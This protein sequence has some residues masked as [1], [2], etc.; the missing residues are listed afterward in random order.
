ME[1]YQQTI[2]F[3]EKIIN[4]KYQAKTYRNADFEGYFDMTL[5]VKGGEI[6][7][8][9]VHFEDACV[10]EYG[11]TYFDEG[12]LLDFYHFCLVLQQLFHITQHLP[13]VKV[14]NARDIERSSIKI[15]YNLDLFDIVSV[16]NIIDVFARV[17]LEETDI[18][19]LFLQENYSELFTFFNQVRSENQNKFAEYMEGAW[20]AKS[21]VIP[22]YEKVEIAS[23]GSNAYMYKDYYKKMVVG[24]DINA[25]KKYILN[26]HLELTPLGNYY[27]GVYYNLI[28]KQD[29]FAVISKLYWKDVITILTDLELHF[30]T[31]PTKCYYADN[32]IFIQ[33]IDFW[34]CILCETE[35]VRAKIDYEINY[36]GNAYN[37]LATYGSQKS[38][39]SDIDLNTI[40]PEKFESMCVDLLVA[41]GFKK[42][43]QRGNMNTPDKGVDIEAVEDVVGLFGNETR[44]WIFQCKHS[45]KQINR[46][47]IAEIPLLL[48]EFEADRFGLFSSALFTPMTQDRI[49]ML[50]RDSVATFDGNQIKQILSRNPDIMKKYFL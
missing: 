38:L 22:T 10:I 13:D 25:M 30:N 2:D 31:I 17:N 9:V 16:I 12:I 5:C 11:V 48:K 1:K 49:K 28:Q 42:T 35:K 18:D 41:Q 43:C 47:D 36:I 3:L 7:I 44:K 34:C 8:S 20:R 4:E 24:F 15:L 33:V 21:R 37:E 19:H 6:D 26:Q 32:R 14:F 29:G 27:D 40:S 23:L 46:K 39:N 50:P 45:K